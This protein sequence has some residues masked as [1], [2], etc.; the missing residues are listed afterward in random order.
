RT[1]RCARSNATR[2]CRTGTPLPERRVVLPANLFRTRRA[3]S[4][5]GGARARLA[6]RSRGPR[7][8]HGGCLRTSPWRRPAEMARNS[9]EELEGRWVSFQIRSVY[10]PD[11]ERLLAEL[12]GDHVLQGRVVGVSDSGDQ[13]GAFLVVE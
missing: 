7:A 10:I 3:P 12:Y 5:V 13:T 2:R 11:K 4:V 1:P 6:L 9:D 8:W